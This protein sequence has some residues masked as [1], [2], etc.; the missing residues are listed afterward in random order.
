MSRVAQLSARV[1]FVSTGLAGLACAQPSALVATSLSHPLS[2]API[3]VVEP[4]QIV[5][6]RTVVSWD[7]PGTQL[8]GIAGDLL[9]TPLTPGGGDG[10]VSNLY[11]EFDPGG[12]IILGTLVGDDVLGIDVAPV[13][14]IT[15]LCH[16]VPFQ[17]AG[18]DLVGYDWT[19]PAA[20]GEY[21]FGFTPAPGRE[22]V[23]IFTSVS[24]AFT[25]AA[26]TYTP[27]TLTVVPAPGAPMVLGFA[28]A[29]APRRS[30]P[31]PGT[32]ATR[33]TPR[34]APARSHR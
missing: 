9:A 26:T 16:P 7:R 6:V 32:L 3:S 31:P 25:L 23:R 5:R 22:F 33:A 11:S 8:A 21:E 4:G 14:C 1:A 19:A 27:A 34:S 13:L 2:G 18:I 12:T 28:A 30:R 10:V 20:P 29:L 17:W 24:P 15:G